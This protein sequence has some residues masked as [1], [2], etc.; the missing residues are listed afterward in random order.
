MERKVHTFDNGIKVYDDHLIPAQR[1]RYQQWNVHEAE[2]EGVF[3]KIIQA[4][5]PNGCYVNVG[6]AIGY[7]SILAKRLA[8]GLI[9]HAVE[10]LELHRKYFLENIAL[11]GLTP[12][13]FHF[14]TEGIS[15]S[16]GKAEF[17]ERGYGSSI[18]K[19]IEKKELE[20]KPPAGD[21][22]TAPE[23][24]KPQNVTAIETKTLD[25]LIQ[26]IERPVELCQMDVQGLEF[27]VLHGARQAMQTGG[28]IT[29]LIGTHSQKLHYDCSMLLMKNGY[30]VE[31]D[32]FETKT[33]P[34]GI[35]VASKG[36]RRLIPS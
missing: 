1:T 18:H 13:D 23:Q 27:G 26:E 21:G 8:P 20:E 25:S 3:V 30:L 7:Y 33:Q 29:F 34:D 31:Y 12:S 35:L 17:M 36:V 22:K 28:I 19:M 14:H 4:L 15:F 10:P 5:P 32:Q 16:D 9:V 2:E 11:N 6:A 24:K